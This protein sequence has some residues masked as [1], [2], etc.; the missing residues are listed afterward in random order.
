MDRSSENPPQGLEID[1]ESARSHLRVSRVRR[2]G[3]C[4]VALALASGLAGA[5]GSGPLAE[6]R[7]RDATGELDVGLSRIVRARAP[8]G[9]LVRLATVSGPETR[10]GIRL[11]FDESWVSGVE[12]ESI[13]PA[14]AAMA[15]L[16]G[17][18]VLDF[19]ASPP[20]R[21]AMRV[22]PVRIGVLKGTITLDEGRPC[23]FE[24]WVLP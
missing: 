20:A 8:T 7:V 1:G 6:E 23:A 12:I 10:E 22:V 16:G 13:V 19:R 5:F 3:W 21:I 9:F 2:A 17:R 24:Q 14:P 4:V 11:T 18:L 15:T